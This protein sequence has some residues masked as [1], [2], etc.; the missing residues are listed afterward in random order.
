MNDG[1]V[2]LKFSADWCAPCKILEPKLEK[3]KEEFQQV[4]FVSVDVDVDSHLAEKHQI[5]HLPTVILLRDGTE[6]LRVTGSSLITPLRK[7]FGDL[8]KPEAA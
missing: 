7:A 2:A 3:L 5:K 6:V 1:F 8:T 4:S